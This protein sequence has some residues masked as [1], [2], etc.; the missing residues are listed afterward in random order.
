MGGILSF[1]RLMWLGDL[2]AEARKEERAGMTQEEIDYIIDEK[3]QGRVV[4]ALLEPTPVTTSV[5]TVK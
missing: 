5:T 3:E 2:E 4:S 1:T